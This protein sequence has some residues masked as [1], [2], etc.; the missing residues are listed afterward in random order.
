MAETR[1]TAAMAATNEA[2][3]SLRATSDHHGKSI[4]E[5]QK[6]QEIHTRTMN[7]MNQHLIS[8]LQKLNTDDNRSQ[9]PSSTIPN[10]STMTLGKPVRLDFP[11]FSGDDPASWVYKANQYFAYYQTPAMEKLLV[12]SFHMDQEAL[13]W[14][15][16]AEDAGIFC[17]WEGMVQALYVRFGSTPYDDPMEAL[18]RLKQTSSVAVYKAEFEALSNRIKGL[19]STHKMSCFLSGLRDEIR[20][21]VRMLNPP[22][23]NAAFGLAKIQEE[24]WSSCKRSSRIQ[25][26]SGKPSILGPPRVNTFLEAKSRIPIKRISPAQMED[27]K[28]KGL[29]Y[30]C[31]DKWS[32][33][34]KCKSAKIFL[35]EGIDLGLDPQSGVKITELEEDLG[36]SRAEKEDTNANPEEVEI[37]LYAL[38]GNPTPGTMR[39]RGKINGVSMVVLLDTGS[40]HNFIDAALVPGLKLAVDQ[41]QTLEVKVANGALIRTKG[42]CDQVPVCLQ[43]REFSI[44]FHVLPLGGCDVVLGTQWLTTLGDIQWNFQFLTMEFCHQ[45]HNIKLQG[46][47][48]TD[49]HLINGDQFLKTPIK[50]GLLVHISNTSSL[51]KQAALPVAVTDLLQDFSHVF[52]TPVGLPPLRGHEHHITLKDG[53]QP[54]CQRPY[55]YPFYQKNEIEKIVKE[56][57]NAGSIRNSCSPFSSPVLLVRKADGSWRMCIDYRQLNL[58]TIKDKFPIPVIDELLDELNGACIFSKLDLRSGYHQIRMSEEDIPKTAFR[59]HEGHYEFLVMPFGLTNAPST[60]QSLMNQVFRPYLRRFVL[61][62]FDDILVYSKSLVEHISHLKTVLEVLTKEKLFAKKSKCVFAC[63]EVEYLGHLISG[64]GVRTDPRKTMAMQQWPTPKDVKALRGFLG[65]TGYY[66][67]FVRG[68]GQIAAP[69]TALLRKDSFAWTEEAEMAF[70]NLKSAMSNPPVLALPNFDKL[71]V[72]ECDASGVGLGAVLMQEGRAI[73]FHS[74]A[75][76]GRSLALST[77]EKELLALVTAVQRWR[78]YLVGNSFL[79][80]TDQ[81]SLKYILEQ[82]IGTPAQQKWITK[83]LGYAFIVEYKKGKENVVA[84]ALSRQVPSDE[85]SSQNGVLCMISFPTPDWLAQLKSSYATDAHVKSILEAFQSGK[86]GPKG[87]SMHNGL[88][89]YK[90]RMYVGSCEALKTA[91]LQQV[92][93]GPWGGHSGVLKT[94][95]RVQRDFYWP[96]LKSDV[97]KYVRECDTC[98]RLKHETCHPAGLLQPLPIPERPW[99]AVSMDFVEGLPKSQMKEVVMVVVDRFTKFVH[100]IALS[101]P[102]TAS[103][104]ANLYL[105]HVFKLHGMPTS[106][107][108]D[109]DPVF[110]SHFWQELMTL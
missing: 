57:L 56:L 21:P 28:K 72:V 85:I 60:F 63:E 4:Q 58:N 1:S 88:L 24:Y 54:V 89:L 106:I 7:E 45:G 110:T 68:Y 77:Y 59:T 97:R 80:R 20:L 31:D 94:L 92:H 34:H 53:V 47:K 2:I 51:E 76:K 19:S 61:V 50:K 26:E 36:S 83:L 17:N 3:S 70:Q 42:F 23:L 33:G 38:I 104:V 105:Q 87:F 75:L 67:K 65:L 107:V 86:E 96:G 18:T 35:L 95:H 44:Q 39:I 25:Q 99:V 108:N 101:H 109:R 82:K 6:I 69:L 12:A 93:D 16:D 71:F 81:Q 41:S 103:K 55:R 22:S 8:I 49:S 78:P 91:I 66:R 64:E 11:R 5:M 13:V 29:C 73:A 9:E 79:V 37:T 43:G 100:F 30:N 10:S 27:R 46:L 84:D 62:F 98:Q 90:G 74:Q 32:P 48:Q 15:Q 102:Y 40:T 14:Y 52:D